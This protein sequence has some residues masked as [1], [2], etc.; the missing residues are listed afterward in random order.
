[1]QIERGLANHLPVVSRRVA[2]RLNSMALLARRTLRITIR[3]LHP[4][5][6]GRSSRSHRYERSTH[7]RLAV[8]SLSSISQ[9]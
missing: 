7:A 3:R 5:D 6:Q 9:A 2:G 8:R 4:A 1:M